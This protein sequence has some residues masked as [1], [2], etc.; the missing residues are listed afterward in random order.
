[1]WLLIFQECISNIIARC[2]VPLFFLI[3]SILFFSKEQKYINV[4]KKKTKTILIPYLFWN[5]FWIVI[6][7]ILQQSTFAEAFFSGT[8]RRIIDRNIVEWLELYGLGLKYPLLPQDYPLWFMRD[9]YVMFLI[10]PIIKRVITKV[11]KF[12]L[13]LGIILLFMPD[14]YWFKTAFAWFL[15]GGAIVKLDIHMTVFDR[16]SFGIISMFYAISLTVTTIITVFYNTTFINTLFVLVGIC[17]WTRASKVI[18]ESVKCRTLIMNLSSYT[19]II[20]V[21]HE[22]TLSSI[23]KV[24]L[25]VL[26]C[27][28]L[29]ILLE[30]ILLPFF[31]MII[32]IILGKVMYKYLPKLYAITT[33]GR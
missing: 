11:P 15:I 12:S 33:G 24:L 17:F 27:T 4:I 7:I 28:D 22:L 10:S 20:Y 32:C 13:L 2:G 8:N 14:L 19:M 16:T 23:K 25:K 18:S 31:I 9:L 3:S 29:F 26:P 6:W 21:F 30:Y 1:M 5:T